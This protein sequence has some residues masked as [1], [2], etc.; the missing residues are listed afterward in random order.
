MISFHCYL[1]LPAP[2]FQ[3][4]SFV[5]IIAVKNLKEGSGTQY[6]CAVIEADT[7]QG[8]V[9]VV[10]VYDL[11]SDIL[12]MKQGELLIIGNPEGLGQTIRKIENA[13]VDGKSSIYPTH[14]RNWLEIKE[15]THITSVIL[16]KA[17]SSISSVMPEKKAY[18]LP[19]LYENNPLKDY[20]IR[21][22][23]DSIDMRGS[24]GPTGKMKKFIQLFGNVEKASEP[25]YLTSPVGNRDPSKSHKSL[26][27]CYD[28]TVKPFDH[29]AFK[30]GDLTPGRPNSCNG[31]NFIPNFPSYRLPLPEDNAE[32][33]SL[34]QF[35]IDI[36]DEDIE[37]EEI[38][39]GGKPDIYDEVTDDQLNHA[40]I[41]EDMYAK[42]DNT[43]DGT[44][45]VLDSAAGRDGENM[46]DIAQ[47]TQEQNSIEG[48]EEEQ[49]TTNNGDLKTTEEMLR[50]AHYEEAR[51]RAEEHQ[52]ELFDFALW[53]ENKDWLQWIENIFDRTLSTFN[54]FFCAKYSDI[55]YVKDKNA[56]SNPRGV[57]KS[58]AENN[59][60]IREHRS[61]KSHMKVM[62]I[63]LKRQ[64][65]GFE[66]NIHKSVEAM[67]FPDFIEGISYS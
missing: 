56:L 53:D 18:G 12:P 9:R 41:I 23:I 55:Y 25:R 47:A 52:S 67:E 50:K 2:N 29:S 44:C 19:D 49:I 33:P 28:A 66:G 14:E 26:S 46:I 64:A 63:H 21:N 6:G 10:A 16:T 51:P 15:K 35:G 24:S 48:M 32:N 27:R 4:D 8:F 5:E 11:T 57:L 1:S 40:A 38:E 54:C 36:E 17:T 37:M 30:L 43:D 7:K 34:Y 65:A 61:K 13:N 42:A 22:M 45:D 20:I 31:E 3:Q 62:D 59:R 60:L 58:R 39:S